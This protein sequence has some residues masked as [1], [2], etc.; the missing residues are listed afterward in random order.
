[1]PRF[2]NALI[3]TYQKSGMSRLV[4]KLPGSWPID[5]FKQL[6]ALLPVPY[7]SKTVP[8]HAKALPPVHHG[9]VVL[10]TG[11]VAKVLDTQTHTATIKLLTRLG[12][13]VRTLAQQ[14]CCG[15]MHAHDGDV[16]RA[17]GLARTNINAFSQSGACAVL[18]NSSGCGAF[19]SEYD[20]LLN[21]EKSDAPS[22]PPP[23]IIDILDFLLEEGQIGKLS[24]QGLKTKVAVHEPCSQ[25]NVLKSQDLIYTALAQIPD[26]DIVALANNAMCCGAGGTQMMTQPELASPLRDEKV[27]ALLDSEAEILLSTNLT[28]ALHLA[29]GV[30]ETG[31]NILA[32]HPVT[33]LA[34]QMI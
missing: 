32:M 3:H 13:G 19:L 20:T 4:Q 7:I 31:R 11:C 27:Q 22:A 12:Y 25:R 33:L 23:P 8:H 29:Q 24:F 30:R 1:M 15:A 21:D 9:D 6:S 28:C 14:T 2:L 16:E 10:F 26:L 18:Y 5:G 17:K 34:Q